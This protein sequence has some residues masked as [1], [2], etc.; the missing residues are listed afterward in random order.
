MRNIIF[1]LVLLLLSLGGVVVRKTYFRLPLRE[2]KRR[3]E[4]HDAAAKTFYRAVA[5][6]NS[7]RG[8]L[9]LYIGLTAAGGFI[10]LARELHIWVSLAVVG[11]LLWIGFSLVPSSRVTKFGTW[12]TVLVTPIIV[13]FLN[14]LYPLLSRSTDT[15]RR[16]YTAP[17]H[18]K[19]FEREDLIHLIERQ[20]EQ[21]DSRFTAEELEIAVRALSFDDY[22]V[23]DVMTPRKKIKTVLASDTLGPV[24]INEVHETRQEQ[25]LVRETAKG[26]FVGSLR[27]SQLG[28]D[29][30]GHVRDVMA[31]TVYYVHESDTLGEALHAFF[32]TNYPVFVVV[33]S[34]E[35]YLGIITVEDILR[36]LLGH[37][38]GDD[39]DQYAD[40]E[41]VAARHTPA[42][43]PVKTDAEVVE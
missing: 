42:E 13:W 31:P 9:W 41:A 11:P 17:D 20:Q 35:E 39:F 16:R 2:L 36:V 32:V 21:E 19:L 8:L 14:Y 6:G 3:A 38:P 25:V 34:V 33:N 24:L 23:V 18:T 4:R 1:A 28:L 5:Y 30:K 15:V 12:L 26:P 43:T 27:F 22:R 37:L 40:P 29:S 10:L 7:L